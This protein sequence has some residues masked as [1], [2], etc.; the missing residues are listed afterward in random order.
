MKNLI[1]DLDGT[2]T[3]DEEEK[4]Y[5]NKRANIK[6]IA[7]LKEYKSQG[8]RITIYTSRNM[9]TFKGDIEKIKANTLPQILAWLEKHA[10]PYDDIVIGKPW[11]G[12]DGFYV[13]DKAIR[14]S[15]FS[16]LSYEEI[17]SLLHKERSL[18]TA[19]ETK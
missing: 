10:V 7:K 18:H 17:C 2:L 19:K 8:F 3:I 1:L 16:T 5:I 15:E 11:C 13:D 6:V 14:P 9:R 4:D 12:F